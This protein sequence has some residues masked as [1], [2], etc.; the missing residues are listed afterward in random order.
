A[1]APAATP[2]PA[3]WPPTW[4]SRLGGTLRPLELAAQPHDRVVAL[5]HLAL[6]QRDDR[7]V[8]DVDVL[9]A[10]LGAA[11]GDVA[12]PD[13]HRGPFLGVERV[14]GQLGQPDHEPRP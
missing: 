14:H 8:G 4:A 2:R 7:V 9:G 12:V 13:A 1:A 10:H 6:L 5:I 11:L 3:L